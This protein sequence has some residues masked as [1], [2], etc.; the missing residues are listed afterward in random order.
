MQQEHLKGVEKKNFAPSTPVVKREDH[1]DKMGYQAQIGDVV[2]PEIGA[3]D[4]VRV[5][6]LAS[7][8]SVPLEVVRKAYFWGVFIWFSLGGSL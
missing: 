1:Y 6:I 4:G 8:V 5:I 7:F 2:V 3:T